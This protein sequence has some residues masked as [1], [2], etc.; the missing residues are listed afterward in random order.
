[1][2]SREL[3]DWEQFSFS[4]LPE[5]PVEL[6]QPSTSRRRERDETEELERRVQARLDSIPRQPVLTSL[7]PDA[8]VLIIVLEAEAA[9]AEAQQVVFEGCFENTNEMSMVSRLTNDVG[10]RLWLRG[11][12]NHLEEHR[13]AEY[14]AAVLRRILD[15]LQV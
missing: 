9:F 15:F 8:R 13:K 14:I 7:Q 1:M 4:Q 2:D 10:H 5:D 12:L 3:E 11:P 6:S